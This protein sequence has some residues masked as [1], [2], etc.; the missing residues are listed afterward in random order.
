MFRLKLPPIALGVCWVV[1][2]VGVVVMWR[3]LPT[4]LSQAA[5]LTLT[6]FT[7]ITGYRGNALP[8]VYTCAFVGLALI[9]YVQAYFGLA[10]IIGSLAV[11]LLI[12]LI[13]W[14]KNYFHTTSVGK[15]EA[16]LLAFFVSQANSIASLWPVSFY[17]RALIVGLVFYLFWHIFENRDE[18]SVKLSSHFAFVTIV[19]IL[20]VGSIIWA[21]FPQ[22]LSF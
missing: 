13:T 19:A 2:V 5:V 9:N 11:F 21:N 18:S 10:P 4:T 8:T 6:I 7:I 22:L 17:N 20:I 1:I 3:L 16:L 14:I 12:I 15:L